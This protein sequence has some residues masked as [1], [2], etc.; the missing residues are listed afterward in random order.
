MQFTINPQNGS[1]GIGGVRLQ[2][3]QPKS[4]IEPQ[5]AEL[6]QGSR[7]HGNGYE[8]LYLEG[9]SFGGQP[10]SV[11]LCFHEG[12]LEQASWNVELR[13]APKDGGWPT[14]QAIDE[15]VAFVRGIL[16]QDGLN[17][18]DDPK[19]FN[20]GEAWSSFDAKGFLASNGLRYRLS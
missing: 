19:K 11:G 16:T 8:W 14:R 2:P 5:I 7:D 10:V 6:V 13:D 3:P 9:L 17:I 18:D 4:E 1:L 20:W 15:E 12:R